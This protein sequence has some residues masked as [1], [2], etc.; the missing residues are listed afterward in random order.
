MTEITQK[1]KIQNIF[2][3][4][5]T[6]TIIIFLLAV[7]F[8]VKYYHSPSPA[9]TK[10][11]NAFK[12]V[13]QDVIWYTNWQRG[14]NIY[15]IGLRYTPDEVENVPIIG[16]LNDSF[17]KK[18]RIYIAFDP[19]SSNKSFK[20]LAH[21]ASELT[22]QLTGPLGREPIAACTRGEQTNACKERP[23]VS[24]D[25]TNLNVIILRE[26][27]PTYIKLNNTCI[28]MQGK[29]NELLRSS[30][31]AL[32][33]WFGIIKNPIIPIPPELANE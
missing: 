32:Y 7:F 4:C 11:Y 2:V 9:Q 26:A 17:N 27:E 31:K 25:N 24:C 13:K 21:A 19:F 3:I 14:E 29:E 15:K 28:I 20:Y 22:T 23:V 33:T 16:Q 30:E 1:D 6:L 10:T 8:G 5:V 18:D 12:F